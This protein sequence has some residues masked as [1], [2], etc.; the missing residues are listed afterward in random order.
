MNVV[1]SSLNSVA[2]GIQNAVS[3]AASSAGALQDAT[4]AGGFTSVL[5][6][7]ISEVNQLH[8]DAAQKVN[9]LL[10]GSGEDVHSATLAVE[11]A[12][13]SFDLM[14]QVR[15]KV[16]SAYQEISRMQF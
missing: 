8:T 2:S 12:S 9:S 6:S 1:S 3:S 10:T 14:L 16:V 11:R 4:G 13:L 5:N 15:N 7:A